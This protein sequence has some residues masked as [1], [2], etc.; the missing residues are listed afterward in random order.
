MSV[1]FVKKWR[2]ST[3]FK[4]KIVEPKAPFS[5]FIGYAL[6]LNVFYFQCNG[7]LSQK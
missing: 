4:C 2:F 7:I 6:L 5:D 3:F 1:K